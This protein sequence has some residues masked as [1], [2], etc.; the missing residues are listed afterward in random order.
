VFVGAT[1]LDVALIAKQRWRMGY[2]WPVAQTSDNLADIYFGICG[3]EAAQGIMGNRV[4]PL[5]LKKVTV[6]KKYLDM[7]QRIID[8]YNQKYGVPMDNY[9]VFSQVLTQMSQYFECA[10]SI[11]TTEPDAMMNAIRGGTFDTFLGKYTFSGTKTY[12]APVVCGY[13]CGMGIIQG[14][15]DVYMNEFPLMDADMWYDYLNAK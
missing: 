2:K 6:A 3:K 9:G 14:D 7:T 10:Q 1:V 4:N 13:P 11:G 5:E 8:R 15:Q 12:G